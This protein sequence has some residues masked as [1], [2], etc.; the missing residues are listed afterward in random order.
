MIA[1]E[2]L[3]TDKADK[4]TM[5]EFKLNDPLKEYLSS[6]QKRLSGDSPQTNNPHT[7]SKQLIKSAAERSLN[8]CANSRQ[9]TADEQWCLG[10]SDC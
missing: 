5:D 8:L 1:F 6:Y 10:A 7:P 2:V 9:S 4:E 3:F